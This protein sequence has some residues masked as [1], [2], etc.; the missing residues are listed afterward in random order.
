[1]ELIPSHSSFLSVCHAG[2]SKS[3]RMTFTLREW[4]QVKNPNDGVTREAFEKKNSIVLMNRMK[5]VPKLRLN[6]SG[7]LQR[8]LQWRT[9]IFVCVCMYVCIYIYV[10]MYV[11]T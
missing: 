7:L 11:R 8:D 1:V 9:Y 3:R 5:I 4:D 2:S 10:C 6:F